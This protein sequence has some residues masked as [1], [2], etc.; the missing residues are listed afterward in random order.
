MK[1]LFLSV[2]CYGGQVLEAFAGSFIHLSE[3]CAARDINICFDTTENESLIPAPAMFPW[4]D[5]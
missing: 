2:P 1:S 4:V 3:L 5:L